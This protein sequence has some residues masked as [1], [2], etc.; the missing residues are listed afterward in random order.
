MFIVAIALVI[1]LIFLFFGQTYLKKHMAALQYIPT[2]ST[3]VEEKEVVQKVQPKKQVVVKKP[4]EQ[5]V[6]VKEKKKRIIV[7]DPGH[8]RYRD[9]RLEPIGPDSHTWKPKMPA[10]AYGVSTGQAEYALTL[11]VANRIKERLDASKYEVKLTRTE[12]VIAKS[13]K[14]RAEFANKQNADLYI[15]LHADGAKDAN[16]RGMYIIMAHENNRYTKKLMEA[17]RKVSQVLLQEIKSAKLDTH[18]KGLLYADQMTALNWPN[19]PSVIVELGYLNN[20][21]DDERLAKT[22]YQNRIAEALARGIEKA[23]EQ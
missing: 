1:P 4:M 8:Q 19:M 2:K 17:N 14:E 9:Q 20:R 13:T 18:K 5:P 22:A 23:V 10:S 3:I 16:G 11:Q 21:Q 6:Q 12:H 7:I 15:Q